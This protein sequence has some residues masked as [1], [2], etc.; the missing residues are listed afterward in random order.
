MSGFKVEV[1]EIRETIIETCARKART[2]ET[3]NNLV[4][5]YSNAKQKEEVVAKITRSIKRKIVSKEVDMTMNRIYSIP[6]W[7]FSIP[8]VENPY[9]RNKGGVTMTESVVKDPEAKHVQ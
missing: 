4:G 8:R 7:N 1:K 3:L 2:L 5:E 9:T 6:E